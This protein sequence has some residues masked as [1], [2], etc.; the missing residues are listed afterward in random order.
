VA[1][2]RIL[3]VQEFSFLAPGK[4]VIAAANRKPIVAGTYNLVFVVDNAGSYLCVGILAPLS[5]KQGYPHKILIPGNIISP[6]FHLFDMLLL[7]SL[8]IFQKL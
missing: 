5:R 8:D 1:N 3:G 2:K 6:F 4:F 7:R